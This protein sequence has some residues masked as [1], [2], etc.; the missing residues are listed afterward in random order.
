MNTARLS[1]LRSRI[2]DLRRRRAA[3]RHGAG[4][5]TLAMVVL[6]IL[7]ATF[8]IDWMFGLNRPQRAIL[9]VAAGLGLLYGLRKYVLP[10]FATKETDLDVALMVERKQK[11]DSDLVAAIQF[12]S[13]DA[14]T[15]GSAQLEG[16]VIDY[17]ADFSKGWNIFEG[18]SARDRTRRAAW[19][20]ATLLLIG[21][22]IFCR[23]DFGRAF[24]HR[25]LLSHA[26]YPT[27]TQIQSVSI[28]AQ[29]VNLSSGNPARVKLPYGQPI[30]VEVVGGGELPTRGKVLFTAKGD[31]AD[32]QIALAAVADAGTAPA[33]TTARYSGELPKLVDSLTAEVYLGDAWTDP[34]FVQ[35]TPLPVVDVRLTPTPPPYAGAGKAE[36]APGN[37]IVSVI[38]G[39]RVDLEVSCNNKPLTSVALK[40]DDELYPLKQTSS[41]SP[42][43]STWRL[44]TETTPLHRVTKPLRY[45]IV[46]IDADGLSPEAPV[47]GAIRIRT[48]NRPRIMGDVVTRSVLP[49]GT[50]QIEYR[51][52]DDFGIQRLSLQLETLRGTKDGSSMPV[53]VATRAMRTIAEGEWIGGEALPIKAAYALDLSSLGLQK[54]DQVRITLQVVD[55]RGEADG[56]LAQS[57]PI[58]LEVTDESGILAAISESDERSARQLDAIIERQLGV[59]GTQ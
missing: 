15:W 11:L 51:A 36:T 35:M 37:R 16:A 10:W 18:F 3:V 8:L 42:G 6:G 34:I 31:G 12:D 32:A 38:E 24:L 50:P 44:A 1:E 43:R 9:F 33:T 45:E 46:A 26:H 17:V 52:S 20:A 39:S 58:T 7:T 59:G 48:D 13:P 40:V 41:E 54:G 55:Y 23:P 22:A 4:Y 14:A 53:A 49:N 25:M 57:E 19:L 56:Q 28:G 5:A 2:S 30:K 21:I 29:P 27:R 47:T